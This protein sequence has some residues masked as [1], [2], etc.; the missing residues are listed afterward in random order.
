MSHEVPA[1]TEGKGRADS[2]AG[3]LIAEISISFSPK[4]KGELWKS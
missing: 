1:N 3:K 4:T 2:G